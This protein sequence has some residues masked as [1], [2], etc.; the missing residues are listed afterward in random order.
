M[1]DVDPEDV[2]EGLEHPGALDEILVLVGS[3]ADRHVGVDQ[4]CRIDRG[5]CRPLGAAGIAQHDDVVA[6][7]P[8]NPLDAVDLGEQQRIALERIFRRVLIEDRVDA[9]NVVLLGIA[10][11]CSVPCWRFG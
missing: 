4:L 7:E 11:H 2:L 6:E 9:Q 10:G 5:P 3:C 1:G 8:R